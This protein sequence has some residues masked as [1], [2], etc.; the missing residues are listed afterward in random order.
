MRCPHSNAVKPNKNGHENEVVRLFTITTRTEVGFTRAK[1]SEKKFR[2][3]ACEDFV[4]GKKPAQR[5]APVK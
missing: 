4:F 3:T 1:K 2:K 5:S